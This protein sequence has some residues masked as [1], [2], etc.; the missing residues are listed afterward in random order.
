MLQKNVFAKIRFCFKKSIKQQNISIF[1]TYE[2]FK[3]SVFI[4]LEDV[5]LHSFIDHYFGNDS[6]FATPYFR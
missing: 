3:N 5:V 2:I 4:S 1:G 6:I